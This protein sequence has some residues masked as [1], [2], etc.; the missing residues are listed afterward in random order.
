MSVSVASSLNCLKALIQRPL[1][2]RVR[3]RRGLCNWGCRGIIPLPEGVGEAEPPRLI[4]PFLTKPATKARENDKPI[5][6]ALAASEGLRP[7]SAPQATAAAL[8]RGEAL[9]G[10]RFRKDS[11]REASTGPSKPHMQAL[12]AASM[13]P[14]IL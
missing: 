7:Q 11:R 8:M 5:A 12:Q 10:G 13:R 14:R 2:I 3:I 9:A 1:Q 4:H 6:T